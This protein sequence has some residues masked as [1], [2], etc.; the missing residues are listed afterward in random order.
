MEPAR[1]RD[2]IR[3]ESPRTLPLVVDQAQLRPDE[4]INLAPPRQIGMGA[5]ASVFRPTAAQRSAQGAGLVSGA[6]EGE[7]ISSRR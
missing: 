2:E 4:R 3:R 1:I 5:A 6:G 7:E